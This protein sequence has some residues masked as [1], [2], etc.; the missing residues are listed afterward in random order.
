MKKLLTIVTM[1]ALCAAAV[2]CGGN[3]VSSDSPIDGNGTPQQPTPTPEPTPEPTPKSY[4]VRITLTNLHVYSNAEPFGNGE[5]YFT[6]AVNDT[7]RYSTQ[8]SA[9]NNSDHDPATYGMTPIDVEMTEGQELFIYVDGYDDDVDS[10]DPMG[11]VNTG[12]YA[13]DDMIGAHS[14]GAANPYNYD[15][16]YTIDWRQ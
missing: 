13:A 14:A 10:N 16:T 6:F 11:T 12:W 5:L 3:D 9:P 7:V 15:V 1:M 8:I 4:P 2:A